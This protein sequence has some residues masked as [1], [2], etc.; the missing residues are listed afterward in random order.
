MRNLAHGQFK[1]I[2]TLA[3]AATLAAP[4]AFGA[5]A[6]PPPAPEAPAEES[7]SAQMKKHQIPDEEIQVRCAHAIAQRIDMVNTEDGRRIT[8]C[9]YAYETARKLSVEYEQKEQELAAKVTQK[10]AE[11]PD[12]NLE[13]KTNT[14]A[15]CIRAGQDHNEVS[16]QAFDELR[17][18]AEY[19]INKISSL[20]PK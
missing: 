18:K 1:L 9:E 5:D 17:E 20:N 6:T 4:A 16:A 19:S 7:I 12:C 15:L 11:N 2:Y 13:D 3:L 10:E 14:Q 8:R